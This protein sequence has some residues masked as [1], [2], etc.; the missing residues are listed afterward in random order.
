MRCDLTDDPAVIGVAMALG[1]D[2]FS[3]V[4]R[5][6]KLWSWADSHT[7][8]GDATSV[9]ETYA[10]QWLDR[11]VCATGFADALIEQHWLTIDDA[12]LHF[13]NF[14]R[15]NGQTAKARALTSKRMQKN[16]SEKRDADVTLAASQKR[17]QRRE[18][19]RIYKKETK[20]KKSAFEPPTNLQVVQYATAAGL[21]IDAD[22]FWDHYAA[23]GWQLANGRPMKDWQAAARRWHR[24]NQQRTG[25]KPT[26]KRYGE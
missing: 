5:L 25:G 9:T 4:G 15:H 21:A 19:K 20:A 2:E 23:Q 12:G 13:P 11:Y 3:V 26:G 10:K 7:L 16:R 18:E 24:T 17:N 22:A 6:H 14:D 1:M 8:N